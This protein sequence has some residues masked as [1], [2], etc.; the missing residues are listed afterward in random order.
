MA[1]ASSNPA[2]GSIRSLSPTDGKFR[3]KDRRRSLLEAYIISVPERASN[4]SAAALSG[5]QDTFQRVRESF[6]LAEWL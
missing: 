4:Q 1:F 2:G 6:R 5:S 3:V